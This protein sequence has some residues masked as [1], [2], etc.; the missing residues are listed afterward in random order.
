MCAKH[1]GIPCKD[2]AREESWRETSIHGDMAFVHNMQLKFR[3]AI[4]KK[5]RIEIAACYATKLAPSL[6]QVRTAP[7]P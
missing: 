2:T 7:M 3:S 1:H 4:R 6:K 5:V